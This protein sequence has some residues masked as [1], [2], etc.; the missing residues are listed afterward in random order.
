MVE[1]GLGYLP[2]QEYSVTTP[3]GH[4]YLG[5]QFAKRICGVSVIRTLT[6]L[7]AKHTAA[8]DEAGNDDAARPC[9]PW[10]VNG[11]TGELV[12]MNEYGIWEPLSVKMQTIKTAVE[13]AC[14]ILRIDDIVSGSKKRG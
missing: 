6:Q 8:F 10:G 9:C 4:K 11:E 14:M 1:A 5:V 12:D 2:F 3:T 7:R 13:S